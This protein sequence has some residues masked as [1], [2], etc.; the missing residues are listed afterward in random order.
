MYQHIEWGDCASHSSNKHEIITWLPQ[1]DHDPPTMA[2][3]L[4]RRGTRS[5]VSDSPGSIYHADKGR[6]DLSRPQWLEQDPSR[7]WSMTNISDAQRRTLL[8][9]LVFFLLILTTW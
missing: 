9:I 5:L 4:R 1:V 3:C 8:W 6:T 7:P 2:L